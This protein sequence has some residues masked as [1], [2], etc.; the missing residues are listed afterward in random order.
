MIDASGR[1]TTVYDAKGR[2]IAVAQPSTKRVSYLYDGADR[3]NVLIDP[4]NGRTSYTHDAAGQL[5]QVN[6]PKGSL[7]TMLYDLAGRNYLRLPAAATFITYS[8]DVAGQLVGQATPRNNGTYVSRLTYSYDLAGRRFLMLFEDGSRTSYGFDA[9]GQ[10]IREQRTTGMMQV[11]ATYMY[12]PVGNRVL[13]LDS[14]VP[15][16]SS[17][18]AANQVTLSISPSSRTTYLYDQAGNRTQKSGNP[19]ET[20]YDWDAQNRLTT[21]TPVGG[22]ITMT[23]DADGRRVG[24]QNGL[25]A[26]DFIYDYQTLLQESDGNTGLTD[27]QYTSTDEEY[28]G[29]LSAY[30][31]G[32]LLY[33]AFDAQGSADAL[34]DPDA[35]DKAS[36]GYRAFGQSLEESGTYNGTFTWGGDMGYVD[37]TS[38][39]GLYLLSARYYDPTAARFISP[40]PNG[41]DAGDPNVYRY[42]ANDPINAA[43]PSGEFLIMGPNTSRD[44]L[45]W[46]ADQPRSLFG[47][48]WVFGGKGGPKRL[49]S[50]WRGIPV[51]RVDIGGGGYLLLPKP[52]VP[53]DELGRQ[54]RVHPND[55]K[56]QVLR[57]LFNY[58]PNQGDNVW[59][60][61]DKPKNEQEREYADRGDG[62]ILRLLPFDLSDGRDAA[63]LKR[64][65]LVAG[66]VYDL[67]QKYPERPEAWLQDLIQQRTSSIV[68]RELI[69]TNMLSGTSQHSVPINPTPPPI[70]IDPRRMAGL[71]AVLLLESKKTPARRYTGPSVSALTPAGERRSQQSYAKAVK[72]VEAEERTAA[73]FQRSM[74]RSN[75]TA[76]YDLA[77]LERVR[78]REEAETAERWAALSMGERLALVALE[79]VLWGL[80]GAAGGELVAA[81]TARSRVTGVTGHGTLSRVNTASVEKALIDGFESQVG[82]APSSSE[83]ADLSAALRD[84]MPLVESDFTRMLAE[85]RVLEYK[86]LSNFERMLAEGRVLPA[87][88]TRPPTPTVTAIAESGK[89]VESVASRGFTGTSDITVKELIAN[90]LPGGGTNYNLAEHVGGTADSAFRGL[91]PAPGRGGAAGLR[92]PVEF[93]GEGGIVV[94]VE[95]VPGFDTATHAPRAVGRL[96][97]GEAEIA[98]PRRIPTQNIIRFGRVTLDRQG[99]EVVRPEDWVQNPNYRP[100]K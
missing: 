48:Y 74:A 61:W 6:A 54:L 56:D 63:M 65:S 52:S 91:A 39:T 92:T 57:A 58:Y 32:Q 73:F 96:R 8:F 99:R 98:T 97:L 51:D 35:V 55:T 10:L 38:E 69:R 44:A 12:D 15:T 75:P 41:L 42:A 50:L 82:R 18:D 31:S 14:G 40:D 95:G 11:N 9:S 66:A 94:E 88:A 60:G 7:T 77:L 70:P 23:Y 86:P 80:A 46:L 47:Y 49:G 3:R 33:Y 67:R 28:G 62:W 17:Y 89:T 93:A 85:G 83:L 22:P 53:K 59:L 27:T 24:W 34:F 76:S 30:G 26:I 16:T 79:T 84:I 4:D 81:A 29:F 19:S 36:Y 1:T 5:V 100:A 45:K 21:V 2:S 72:A 25:E 37:D 78:K 43:D 71:A 13:L 64:A 20:Y 87:S 90:G 68:N